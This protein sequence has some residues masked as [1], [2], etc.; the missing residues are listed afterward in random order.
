MAEAEVEELRRQLSEKEESLN[1]FKEKTKKYLESKTKKFEE[2]A[3]A[4]KHQYEQ[5]LASLRKENERLK[6]QLEND[7]GLANGVQSVEQLSRELEAAVAERSALKEQ[8]AKLNK[9]QAALEQSLNAAHKD[10]GAA[11]QTLEACQK[12]LKDAEE[13][14]R[15]VH[16]LRAQLEEMPKLRAQAEEVHKLR[17]QVERLSAMSPGE[18][19]GAEEELRKENAELRAKV[20]SVEEKARQALKKAVETKR[21][22]EA[23]NAELTA[24][25]EELGKGGGEVV[26]LQADQVAEL[27][28]RVNE[29]QVE[30]SES[31]QRE[32]ELAKTNR[33]TVEKT[34][35]MLTKA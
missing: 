8:L 23:V 25:L 17:A 3:E 33:D 2:Q 24:K 20:E 1:A 16:M 18:E 22:Y 9:Q 19:G 28:E 30:I 31:K 5:E 6:K 14:A 4:E 11:V 10:K 29:L 7:G 21:H 27:Q 26:D 35:Q 13:S 15:A 12:R 34:K 32:E